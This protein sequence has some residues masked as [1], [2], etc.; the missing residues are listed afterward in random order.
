M[1]EGICF[2]ILSII[3]SEMVLIIRLRKV[4]LA[5][6][7]EPIPNGFFAEAWK[8]RNAQATSS[9]NEKSR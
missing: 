5:N 2:S 7:V 4:S 6:Y 8:G 9:V 3:I 1:L